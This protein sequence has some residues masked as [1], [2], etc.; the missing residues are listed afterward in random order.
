ML[1]KAKSWMYRSVLN[2]E[3]NSNPLMSGKGGD[4]FLGHVHV[5]PSPFQLYTTWEHRN[6]LY[7]AAIHC[8]T[9]QLWLHRI[10]TYLEQPLPAVYDLRAS[11]YI[12]LHCNE[13]P[14]HVNSVQSHSWFG[15]LLWPVSSRITP[16]HYCLQSHSWFGDTP[17]CLIKNDSTH[18]DL[19]HQE[20]LYPLWP[21][22]SRM[23]PPTVTCLIKNDSTHFDLS[24][25]EWL[26]PLWP[27]SS[28]MTP[29]HYCFQ[30]HS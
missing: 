3:E 11:Q 6:T 8:I 20:W 4:C 2:R 26:Y 29:G 30:S 21:V 14:H 15:D 23:T 1:Q 10:T 12:T 28:R 16:G 27:V 18:C 24:H 19:S 7:Y 13:L 25:Q 22:S 5:G 17:T 9:I